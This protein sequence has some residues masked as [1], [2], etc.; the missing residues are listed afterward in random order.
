MKKS[1]VTSHK[2]QVRIKFI[3]F[4]LVVWCLSALGGYAQ[5]Y[6]QRIISLGPSITE[7]LY[8][9]GSEDKLIANTTYCTKPPEAKKKEKI[10]T[11]VE[12]NVEK[13]FNLKPDLVLATSLTNPKAKEKLKKLGIKVITFSEPRSFNQICEQFLELAKLGG[14]EKEAEEIIHKTKASV[15]I[16]KKR[17][18]NLQRPKVLVQVGSKP[19]FVATGNS[20]INDYI[21]FAG[22]INIARNAKVGIYSREQVLKNNPDVIIIVTMGIVGEKE[23]E[24]W[25]KYKT[26]NAVKNDRIYII[27][28]YKL[29]SP[30]PV[31]FGEALEEIAHMLH[32]MSSGK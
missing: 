31:S 13:I 1:S 4:A 15:D 29:C 2:L 8:L 11:V 12:M 27:D 17:V 22:G 24:I 25:D 19:L 28:S 16:I 10:G 20:F 14:K 6:P 18:K 21:E 5:N 7:E 32:P 23:K 3:A 26:L 30:T 9:L